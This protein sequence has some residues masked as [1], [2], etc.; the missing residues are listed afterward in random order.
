MF[1]GTAPS[2]GAGNGAHFRIGTLNYQA[3][4]LPLAIQF[5]RP[6]H[7]SILIVQKCCTWRTELA[8]CCSSERA[9]NHSSHECGDACVH[10]TLI[11]NNKFSKED[12]EGAEKAKQRETVSTFAASEDQ[13]PHGKGEPHGR[14]WRQPDT[15]D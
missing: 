4:V 15:V 11:F 2:S 14:N 3:P 8:R 9:P 7:T 1:T 13:H 6:L 10:Q 5:C 12:S